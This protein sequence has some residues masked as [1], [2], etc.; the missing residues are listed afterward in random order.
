MKFT[1]KTEKSTGRYRSFYPD[2]H[3]IKLKRKEV[4]RIDD[5]IPHRIRLQVV[6]DDI[7]EDENSNC[8]WIWITLK[9][10]SDSLQEAKDFLN[11]NI[12]VITT[13]YNIYIED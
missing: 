6:K 8:E 5:K 13:K 3:Y 4:G 2:H 9:K 7:N 11:A 1:F 12:E 10:E